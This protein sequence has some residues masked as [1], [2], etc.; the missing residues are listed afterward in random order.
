MTISVISFDLDG[1]LWDV[2]P[3]IVRA[4]Q[5]LHVFLA[6]HAPGV[7]ERYTPV[8]LRGLNQVIIERHPEWVCDLTRIRRASIALALSECGHDPELADPAFDLYFEMRNRVQLFEG[9]EQLLTDLSAD[10][11]LMALSNGNSDLKRVGLAEY[12][13]FHVHAGQ[14]GSR[15]PEPTM[16]LHACERMK[17]KPSQV[18]HIG[19]EWCT[20]VEGGC[21][22]G[23]PVIWFNHREAEQRASDLGEVCDCE[24][25]AV[26]S[27]LEQISSVLRSL[28]F[29]HSNR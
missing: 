16:F 5:A 14:I 1:T 2:V 18:V 4:E 7:V 28:A 20:D 24:A 9:V 27:E 22:A 19:D 17:V 29:K 26:V 12:F 6:E 10:Y 25:L 8:Q 11:R 13:E 3:V 15:K 21:R 23:V